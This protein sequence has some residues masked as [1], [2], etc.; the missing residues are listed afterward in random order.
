MESL[1]TY[2][3]LLLKLNRNQSFDLTSLDLKV[4]AEIGIF[5]ALR[6]NGLENTLNS[7]LTRCQPSHVENINLTDVKYHNSWKLGIWHEADESD[8]L[9]QSESY[10]K[11]FYTAINLFVNREKN[12]LNTSKIFSII[13]H[14]QSLLFSELLKNAT[15]LAHSVYSVL[16]RFYN[17]NEIKKFCSMFATNSEAELNE[18]IKKDLCQF[19][20]ESKYFSR[21]NSFDLQ[22]DLLTTRV[23]LCKSLLE[24]KPDHFHSLQSYLSLVYDK[25]VTNA[26]LHKRF[27][28]FF[29]LLIRF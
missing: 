27:Q 25:M 26:V 4:N 24:S 16:G 13:D 6:N 23:I 9:N 15:G 10:H 20:Y 8:P 3:N 1:C 7:L 17:L 14:S 29:L 2:D 5:N 22:D 11:N 12:R 21:M 28:V 18:F 19:E